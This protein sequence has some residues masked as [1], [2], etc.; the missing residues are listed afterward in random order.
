MSVQ[1]QST[2][3]AIDP[4]L[5]DWPAENPALFASRCT[6]CHAL[7]FPASASCMSCGGTDVVRE[8]L[9]SRGKLWSWT[10]QRFMLRAPYRSF[11]TPDTYTPYGIG[12]VELDDALRVQTRL[13]ENDPEQLQ[14]GADMELVFFPQWID[15]DGVVVINYAFQM[16][17]TEAQP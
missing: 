4:N 11:E 7:T 14:I 15:D 16:A 1:A 5:F 17:E 8:T 10:I 13:V 2:Q 12:Y 9:P 6:S 3:R